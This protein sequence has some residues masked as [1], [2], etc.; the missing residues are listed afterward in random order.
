ME[1]LLRPTENCFWVGLF[2]S[3]SVKNFDNSK[4]VAEFFFEPNPLKIVKRVWGLK[5]KEDEEEKEYEKNK[6]DDDEVNDD[7][8]EKQD[9]EA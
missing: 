8:E 2:W 3:G 5:E 7:D 4:K 1:W 9:N 6:E